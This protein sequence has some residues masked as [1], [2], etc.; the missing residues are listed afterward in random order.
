MIILEK[1]N[2][3]LTPFITCHYSVR[4]GKKK[5]KEFLQSKIIG[6]HS[7]LNTL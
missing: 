1:L 2:R 4:T 7:V 5:K 6:I 3:Y